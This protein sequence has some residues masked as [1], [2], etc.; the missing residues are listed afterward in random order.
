MADDDPGFLHHLS[1]AVVWLS[2]VVFL[3]GIAG[4]GYFAWRLSRDTAET[5]AG[6]GGPVQ[7][8]LHRWRP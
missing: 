6:S 8:W 3:V 7:I 4:A 2:L 1:R 5:F